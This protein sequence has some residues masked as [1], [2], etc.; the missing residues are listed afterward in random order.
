MPKR[1]SYAGRRV[2]RSKKRYSRIRKNR[3]RTRVPRPMRPRTYNFTRSFVETIALNS[4]TPPTGWTAV[5]NGLTRSQPF[6]LTNLPDNA[7]FVALFAQYRLCAVKQEYFFADTASVNVV[8]GG[9]EQ[10]GNKQIMMYTIPNSVGQDNAAALNENYFM[11]SQCTKKRLCLNAGAR[12]IKIYTKL[13][14]LTRIYSSEV[15]NQDFSKQRPRFVSTNEPNAQ[16]YGI[17]MRLQRVDGQ[18][19]SFGGTNYPTVKIVTKVYLQCRQV[20]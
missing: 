8:D 18:P 7:E 4:S 2:S 13:K 20:K 17:D 11:Q 14:Q 6:Q 12:P 9:A 19:F 10:S 1:K 3:K 16:H 15:G 5:S